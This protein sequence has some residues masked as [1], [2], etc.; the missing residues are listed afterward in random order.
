MS[1]HVQPYFSAPGVALYHGDAAE[2]LPRLEVDWSGASM[3]TDPVWSN[4]HAD[5]AGATRPIE[6]FASV[7]G[8]EVVAR[9]DRLIVH[10]GRD[11]DPRMLAAVPA[12]LPFLAV[13]WLRR[14]PPGY[15]GT[16][17]I[18]GD[19]AYVWGHSRRPDGASVMPAEGQS[20]SRGRKDGTTHPCPRNAQ[21]VSWLLRWY[22]SAGSLV[23]DPFA[24]S[25]TTLVCGI[26]RGLEVVGIEID[27]RWCEEGA[28]RLEVE[29][30][31]G[32]IL[33]TPQ[34]RRRIAP[35]LL[36]VPA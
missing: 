4:S 33:E 25:C 19:V 36:D 15:K 2:I 12:A 14:T 31:Q 28:R 5:L 27:E 3:V 6:V 30:A 1:Q 16:L 9:L 13:C 32:S 11:S 17:L 26:R 8:L 10:L 23:V 24:G 20:A 18:G 21:S 22:V 34:R 29:L 7:V 35:P